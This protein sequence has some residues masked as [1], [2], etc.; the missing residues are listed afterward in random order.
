[1][2][3]ETKTSL[4]LCAKITV[5]LVTVRPGLTIVRFWQ[6]IVDIILRAIIAVSPAPRCGLEDCEGNLLRSGVLLV[7]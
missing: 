5:A 4:G 7:G 2:G 6:G 3:E 1:M